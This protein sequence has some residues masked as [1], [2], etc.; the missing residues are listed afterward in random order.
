VNEATEFPALLA[1][2]R[3][4]DPNAV[5][6]LY[7]RYGPVLRA[8]VR[9]RLHP[10]LR[11]RFDSLDFVQD[12]WTS[13][14]A[15]PADRYHFA[16]HDDLLSFLSRVAC[17][18][19]VE[20][21]RQRFETR[22]DDATRELPI[23]AIPE[24]D[25]RQLT[26]PTATPSQWAIADEELERLLGKFPKGHRAI[27]LRLREGYSLEDIARMANVSAATVNRVVRRLKDITGV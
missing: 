16:T 11:T 6:L 10:R 20:V 2:L 8:A 26:A 21:L 12:V 9:R 5:E 27:V 7:R 22:K 4:G 18:K 3:A 23:D 14:L 19:V 1:G 13:F 24:P 17:N 15:I 25:R